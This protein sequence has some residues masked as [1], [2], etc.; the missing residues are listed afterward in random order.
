MNRLS[1]VI[2]GMLLGFVSIAIPGLSASTVALI[3]GIYYKM[4]NSISNILSDF[5]KSIGFLSFLILGYVMGALAGAIT[6]NTIYKLFPLVIIIIILGFVIGSIPNMA[7]ELKDGLKKPSCWIVLSIIIFVL[8]FYS[9]FITEGETVTFNDMKLP[10]YIALFFV[11]I[12][13]ASTLVIPGV[14]YA[15]LILALGYYNA[16]IELIVNIFNPSMFVSNV[17]ILSIYLAGYLLGSLLFAKIVK[18]LVKKYHNQTTYA[19]FAFVVA[20][21]AIIVSKCIIDNPDFIF[22]YKQLIVGL[23]LGI[24]ALVLMIKFPSTNN[25]KEVLQ[26]NNLIE[27]K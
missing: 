7:K 9:Y 15:V 4:V 13:T 11:G 19:S 10:D 8:L 12:I 22:S 14:D 18:L 20:A 26:D 17:I 24:L 23:T 27:T 5:K 6:I 25:Q 2:K 3:V 21:P 16:I 1:I